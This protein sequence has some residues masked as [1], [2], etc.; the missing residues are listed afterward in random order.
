MRVGAIKAIVRQWKREGRAVQDLHPVGEPAKA[1][2]LARRLAELRRQLH[3]GDAAPVFRS[4][5]SGRSAD[6][7]ADIEEVMAGL[8][9]YQRG[10]LL[11]RHCALPVE[12]IDRR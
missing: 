2:Q 5:P 8:W 7:A 12:M 3:S 9:L 6:A 4:N 1:V 10:K 11:G